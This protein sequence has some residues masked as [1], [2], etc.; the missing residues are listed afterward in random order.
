M[1]RGSHCSNSQLCILWE[2][3]IFCTAENCYWLIRYRKIW[4]LLSYQNSVSLSLLKVICSLRKY[5]HYW[6]SILCYLRRWT[7]ARISA[8]ISQLYRLDEPQ[9]LGSRVHCASSNM[10]TIFKDLYNH[11]WVWL[12][13]PWAKFD[14]ARSRSRPNLFSCVRWDHAPNNSCRTFNTEGYLLISGRC[15]VLCLLDNC[16]SYP[17]ANFGTGL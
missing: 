13:A 9:H 15:Y 4:C 11:H 5:R 14:H 10:F 8:T 12:L 7:L 16:I 6:S 3:R 17:S 2:L 1:E